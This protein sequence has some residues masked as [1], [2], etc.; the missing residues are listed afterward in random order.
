MEKI[1][2]KTFLKGFLILSCFFSLLSCD[3]DIVS[4]A[5]GG[6]QQVADPLLRVDNSVVS[7]QAGTASY[8]YAMELVNGLKSIETVNIYKIYIY[9]K[10]YYR[11][12]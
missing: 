11:F 4:Y 5:D 3:E 12:F 1:A 6:F 2:I 7:F 10:F 8:S 9:R